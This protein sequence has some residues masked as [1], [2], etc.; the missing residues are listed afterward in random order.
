M[1]D[2]RRTLSLSALALGVAVFAPTARAQDDTPDEEDVPQQALPPGHPNTAPGAQG[3]PQIFQPP[4]DSN[5]EDIRLPA[6]TIDVT[7]LDPDNAALPN[8]AVT[9]GI[10]HNSV[11]KGESREHKLGMTDA[12]GGAAF[13]GLATGS[14]IAYRVSVVKDGATF[15]ATPFALSQDKGTRV[16]LHVYPVTHDIK[17]ALVV[18]QVVI[19]AELKDDRVQIEQAVTLFNLGRVAWVLDDLVVSLPEGFQALNGQQGMGGE[20]IEPV[21]KRGARIR[22]T[23]GPGQHTVDFRWQL[24]YDNEPDVSFDESL[25]PNVAVAR[26]LAAASQQMRLV[27][28]G[29]PEAQART[30]SNGERILITERQMRRDEAPLTTLHYELRDIPTPGPARI[31]ATLLASLGVLAG[32]GFAFTS[33]KSSG[34]STDAK[35]ARARLLAEL[36]ELERAHS[37]GDV[38]PQTY[39]RARREII[40]A[41]ARTLALAAKEPP[42]RT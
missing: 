37:A 5:E 9:L 1:R 4:P 23:F 31:V 35:E 26:A 20:G 6:G 13:S 28:T 11:A 16:S 29:F 24:P 10:I 15:W 27:V 25:P 33:R 21:D 42:A 39:E 30:D 19:Y 18:S 7:L 12:S 22:G 36:E 34:A 38:G 32:V 2:L 14:G 17:K 41:I 3:N 8:T 40:D